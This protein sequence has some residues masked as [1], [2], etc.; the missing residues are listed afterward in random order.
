LLHQA[1]GA[2]FVPELRG[3]LSFTLNRHFTLSRHYRCR[4][5][6]PRA[7]PRLL[8]TQVKDLAVWPRGLPFAGEEGYAQVKH[9]SVGEVINLA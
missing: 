3:T 8:L 4:C 1:V 5:F 9:A 6:E 2:V 7:S